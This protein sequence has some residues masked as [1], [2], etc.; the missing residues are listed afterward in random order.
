VTR[1]LNIHFCYNRI[2]VKHLSTAVTCLGTLSRL[3]ETI[4]RDMS[5]MIIYVTMLS[6]CVG[7]NSS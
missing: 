2:F 5:R 4:K 3:V 6:V 7:V 1:L